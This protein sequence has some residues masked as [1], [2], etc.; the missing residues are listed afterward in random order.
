MQLHED[1]HRYANRNGVLL[2]AFLHTLVMNL[3]RDGGH[4]SVHAGQ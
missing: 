3:L 4:L 1:A 2:F